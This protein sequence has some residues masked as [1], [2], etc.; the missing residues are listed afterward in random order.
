[1]YIVCR[2]LYIKRDTVYIVCRWLCIKY[3]AV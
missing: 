2:W 3:G 1:V